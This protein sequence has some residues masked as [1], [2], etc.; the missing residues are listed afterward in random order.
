[1]L[2]MTGHHHPEEEA[3]HEH[4]VAAGAGS[5]GEAEGL[6]PH[7]WL[8]PVRLK[9]QARTVAEALIA[10]DPDPGR[11]ADYRAGRDSVLAELD[12]LDARLRSLLGPLHG[13]TF[14][15]F[16]PAW[17]YFADAYGLVQ[18][19]IE[20]EGSEPSD[21]E[22]TDVQ[23]LVREERV[24][25]IFVQPQITGRAAA[26]VARAAGIRVETLDPLARDVPENLLRAARAIVGA[27]R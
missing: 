22:L 25:T 13:R 18:E 9:I 16:H 20:V 4:E 7:I 10:S 2:A 19:A 3:G 24:S 11:Q 15:V 1:M 26:A 6:D 5:G 23:R 12:T 17:G 14:L 27:G 21:A 8:D